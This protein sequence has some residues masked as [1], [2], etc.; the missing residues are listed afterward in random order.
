MSTPDFRTDL[1]KQFIDG[2]WRDGHHDKRLTDANPFD[3]STVADFG[4]ASVEDVD[5][6]YTAA[7]TAQ[8]QWAKVNPY[9]QRAVFERAIRYVEDH[10]D[11][12]TEIIIDELGGTRLKAAFE[13]GTRMLESED[14]DPAR[15]TAF[16]SALFI[17]GLS[18]RGF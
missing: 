16:I 8:A 5:H 17:A 11:E 2:A 9:Q 3:G 15:A 10:A 12:I 14:P 13:I 6:A 4:M 7:K 1:D 18:A